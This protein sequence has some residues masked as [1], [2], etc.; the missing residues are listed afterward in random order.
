[1]AAYR[2]HKWLRAH[3]GDRCL[4]NLTETD[5]RALEASVAIMELYA[6]QRTQRVLV[7]F[8]A[9]AEQMQPQCRQY[10]FHAIAMVLDWD[11]R[12]EVWVAAAL[13]WPSPL[14]RCAWGPDGASN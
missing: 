10:A 12:R 3:L 11:Q 8:S 7:A 9:V 4:T 6:V 13:P 2:V 14:G 5:R 1:M